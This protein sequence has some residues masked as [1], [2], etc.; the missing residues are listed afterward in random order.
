MEK[1]QKNKTKNNFILNRSGI[2]LESVP[3]AIFCLVTETEG[4]TFREIPGFYSTSGYMAVIFSAH[5][6]TVNCEVFTATPVLV[7]GKYSYALSQQPS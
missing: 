7:P 6:V 3:T 2:I 5:L 1:K 4:Q